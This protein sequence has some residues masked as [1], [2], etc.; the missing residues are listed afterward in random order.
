MAWRQA[1][2]GSSAPSRARTR[3]ENANTGGPKLITATHVLGEE[4]H[5]RRMS[6][7]IGPL[8]PMSNPLNLIARTWA[9]DD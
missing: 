4:F 9:I 2:S 3:C 1:C 5:S 6:A 8:T 7:E